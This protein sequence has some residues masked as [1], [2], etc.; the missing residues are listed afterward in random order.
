[1]FSTFSYLKQR[2]KS[3]LSCYL[4]DRFYFSVSPTVNWFSC[5]VRPHA[6]IW[7]LQWDKPRGWS[8]GH[9]V[10]FVRHKLPSILRVTS[11]RHRE[12]AVRGEFPQKHL[13]QIKQLTLSSLEQENG[14]LVSLC[15]SRGSAFV[16]PNLPNVSSLFQTHVSIFFTA[17]YF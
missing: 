3:Q 16:S 13:T 11:E 15:Y 10:W 6:H 12:I 5:L 8:P 14:D 1:M 4:Q 7:S 9:P 17:S 2:A